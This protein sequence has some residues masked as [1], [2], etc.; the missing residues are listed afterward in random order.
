MYVFGSRASTVK[1]DLIRVNLAPECQ[2][3]MQ[4]NQI[5]RMLMIAE[6]RRMTQRN[7]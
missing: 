5:S 2:C 4:I 1:L 7:Y 3:S 6:V